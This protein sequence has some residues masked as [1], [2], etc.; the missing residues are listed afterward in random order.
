MRLRTLPL[1]LA[2]AAALALPL[3]V[4]ACH[5]PSGAETNDVQALLVARRH[6]TEQGVRS[7]TLVASPRCFCGGLGDIRTTVVNGTV[8]ERVYVADGTSVPD[9]WY[10]QIATVDAMLETVDDA[11]RKDAAAVRV[12]YDSRGIPTR[13]D[14]DYKA[15][16][17]DEE[18]GWSV[19][20][21]SP[22][23]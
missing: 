9:T 4:S 16:W 15:N 5:S 17:F 23:P 2:A 1:R 21:F 22:A 19:V 13:A 11:F 20:G 8:T 3:A 18:F 6:W 12:T 14:I 7:Y 10:N